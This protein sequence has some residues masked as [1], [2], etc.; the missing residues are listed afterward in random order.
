MDKELQQIFTNI[1]FLIVIVDKE[2]RVLRLNPAMEALCG[3]KSEEA[4]G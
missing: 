4:R 1:P 3:F 2:M